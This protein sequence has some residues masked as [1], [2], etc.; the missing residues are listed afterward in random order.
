MNVSTLRTLVTLKLKSIAQY[1]VGQNTFWMTTRNVESKN[2][3]DQLKNV[4]M[5]VD[6]WINEVNHFNC[7]HINK[8]R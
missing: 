6:S 4:S 1:E 2:I 8:F 7:C 3:E 5:V